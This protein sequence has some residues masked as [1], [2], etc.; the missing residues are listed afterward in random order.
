MNVELSER[1]KGTEKQERRERIKESKYN[2]K[3]ERCMVYDRGNSGVRVLRPRRSATKQNWVVKVNS[4]GA[5]LEV[6]RSTRNV[7]W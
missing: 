6:V 7:D 5:S 3:Y 1:D 4:Q 2:R